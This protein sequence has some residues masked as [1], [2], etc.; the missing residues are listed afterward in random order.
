[1]LRRSVANLP[2][3]GGQAPRWLFQ[4]MERLA[5]SIIELIVLD[6][7]PAEMLQRLAD[8]HWFQAFGSVLGFDWHSSGLTTV[9]CGAI[10]QAYR[11]M[12]GQLGI[13]AAGGKGGTSRRAPQEIADIAERRAISQGGDLVYASKLSAKVDSAALQDGYQLYHHCFFFDDQG[14]WAVV[15]QGM[16]DASHYARR[17]HWYAEGETDF[18]NEPHA[19]IITDARPTSVLN[20]VAS[21]SQ[22]SRAA[23]VEIVHEDPARML[24]QVPIR[25]SLFLP[26]RH[27]VEL[28]P[29]EA[30]QLQKVLTSAQTA[31][32][33][34]FEQLLGTKNVGPKTI[35]ALALLAEL[36]YNAPASKQDPAKYSFAHGGKDGHPFPVER[37]LYDQNIS[38]LAQAVRKARVSPNEKDRAL[39]RLQSW[40]RLQD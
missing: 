5:G 40:L 12:G 35:R 6:F 34:N 26:S 28:K 22:A 17:Y 33:G 19:G 30:K 24:S 10:K 4:R 38:L 36:I 20:M 14:R 8:P 31:S 1:M 15:Q 32:I 16:N 23:T 39:R 21:D 2:L 29:S 27:T 7:G 9:T 3:H 13:H 11:R 18:V 37:K 25:E